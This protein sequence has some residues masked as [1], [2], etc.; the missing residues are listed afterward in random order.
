M[1]IYPHFFLPLKSA[2]M[3]LQTI[4]EISS[5]SGLLDLTPWIHHCTRPQIPQHA[6]T[7][8]G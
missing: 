8:F 2:G 3:F 6:I 4:C 5:Q 1:I 7:I